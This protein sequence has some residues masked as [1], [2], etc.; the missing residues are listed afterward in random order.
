MSK[1]T[2]PPEY[3]MILPRI[4]VLL[5]GSFHP[6]L[7][8]PKLKAIRDQ[9]I[10]NGVRNCRMTIDFSS[11]VRMSYESEEGYNLRK[12]EYWINHTDVFI[13]VFFPRTDNASIGVEE[14]LILSS[15]PSNAWRTI[16]AFSSRAHHIPS[17]PSGLSERYRPDIS[18]IRFSNISDI[19]EQAKGYVVQ[20]LA[21]FYF[22]VHNRP[23]GEWE[24]ASVI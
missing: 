18:V 7:G 24:T 22:T 4:R 12:S 11:P 14:T 19:Q 2:T 23:D 5:M 16:V 8:L 15:T 6:K 9:L 20:L 10:Q 3:L 1:W 17:L 13:L 21:R